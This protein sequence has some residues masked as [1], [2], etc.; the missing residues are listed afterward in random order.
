MGVPRD[1]AVC[2]VRLSMG[3]TT[4]ADEVETVVAMLVES[5]AAARALGAGAAAPA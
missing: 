5:A 1:L 4:T 3:A 2:A